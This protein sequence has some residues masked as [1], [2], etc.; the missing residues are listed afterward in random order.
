ML[1]ALFSKPCLRLSGSIAPGNDGSH[2][3]SSH[4]VDATSG[5]FD[6]NVE[7]TAIA[8]AGHRISL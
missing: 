4:T 8:F 2:N 1:R 7:V 5:A 3:V 6:V